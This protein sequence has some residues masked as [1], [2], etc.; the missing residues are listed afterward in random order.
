MS[1]AK[2]VSRYVSQVAK[3]MPHTRKRELTGSIRMIAAFLLSLSGVGHAVTVKYVG[4]VDIANI[5]CTATPRSSFIREI[6]VDAGTRRVATQLND[7]WYLYCDVPT[8][9]TSD[10]IGQRSLERFFNAYIKGRYAC[11]T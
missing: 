11:S 6:C 10:W 9:V 8:S 5:T 1:T 7:T 3:D 4:D 2:N